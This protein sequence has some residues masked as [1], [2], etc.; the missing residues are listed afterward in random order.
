MKLEVI[1]VTALVFSLAFVD[2]Y[3]SKK[4][5]E[6]PILYLRFGEVIVCKVKLKKKRVKNNQEQSELRI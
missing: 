4:N 6:G 2:S 1:L 5:T 3:S